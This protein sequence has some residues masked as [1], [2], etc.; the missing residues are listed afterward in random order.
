MVAV[1]TALT[2][3][4]ALLVIIGESFCVSQGLFFYACGA[5]CSSTHY[6]NFDAYDHSGSNFWLSQKKIKIN[7]TQTDVNVCVI[8]KF[9]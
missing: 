4:F 3:V 1:G 5:K 9:P 6:W 8:F 7:K 2:H